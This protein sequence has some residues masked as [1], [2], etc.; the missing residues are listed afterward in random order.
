MRLLRIEA[1]GGFS[2]VEYVGKS[3]PPYAIL[4]HTWGE[5]HEE[6][7]VRDIIEGS[8]RNKAGYA[9]L[10]FCGK[11][12]A[13]NDLQFFWIDTCCI[14]KT[15][16]AEF[17][18]AINSM[19]RWYQDA[20][21]CYVFLSDVS[22][23][24]VNDDRR[25]I[26]KSKW[27]TRGWTLQELLAP[28]SVEF[29]DQEGDRIGDKDSLMSQITTITGIP[30]SALQ[31]SPLSQFS[32]EVKRSWLGDRQ[33]K[34][35]EDAAYCLL[36]IF[37]VFMPL[38][39]GEGR[40]RA[41]IRLWEEINKPFYDLSSALSSQAPFTEPMNR[42]T[43]S[44]SVPF[45]SIDPD[46]VDQPGMSIFKANHNRPGRMLRASGDRFLHRRR[47][48]TLDLLVEGENQGPALSNTLVSVRD[49]DNKEQRMVSR[50]RN[51]PEIH[52]RFLA[53]SAG[54]GAEKMKD[55]NQQ[56]LLTSTRSR[57]NTS[58]SSGPI[59][60]QVESPQRA[61]NTFS[62]FARFIDFPPHLLGQPNELGEHLH[63]KV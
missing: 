34:R 60:D 20:A 10:I 13:K 30:T 2:L 31:G 45:R 23:R 24:D 59:I 9:K 28:T 54:M 25:S 43:D 53:L 58:I 19:F 55:S 63:G 26:E 42:K 41:F 47:R 14:D 35:V 1:D 15:S 57:I 22:I 29:F 6:V 49:A 61:I 37:N 5:D 56:P 12:A 21:R 50:L 27:F 8:G 11:Q 44:F 17:S 38:I 51:I 18:E 7:T 36:G 33:T 32:V 62:S 40:E 48:E 52:D 46:T 16:S 39:Y 4:S 3:I